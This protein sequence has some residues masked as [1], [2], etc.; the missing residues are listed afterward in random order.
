MTVSPKPAITAGAGYPLARRSPGVGHGV[1]DRVDPGMLGSPIDEPFPNRLIIAVDFGTTYSA[2]S[3][4]PVPQG[5]SSESV[6]PHS[7]QSIENY[8]SN[9]TYIANDQMV[10][11]VPT[12]VIYPLNRHFR[13]EETSNEGPWNV[14]DGVQDEA[15][16]PESVSDPDLDLDH[17]SRHD[18]DGDFDMMSDPS[19]DL[20]R[21]GYQVHELWSIP[22]T[23]SDSSTQPLSRFKLLLDSS[24]VT[25]T[26]REK[27]QATVNELKRQRIV[28]ESTNIIADF[29]THLLKHTQDEL[30]NQGFDDSYRKEIVLCVP[31]IWT[32]K[33]CRH[34]QT[35]L[36]IVMKRSCFQGVDVQNNSIENL[37]IVSEPEAAA[38]FVLT[39]RRDF[40]C[41]D[42]FV[43]LDAVDANTYKISN[44]EP[45]RLSQEVVAPGGGL[46]GSSFLNEKFGEYLKK[47]L[48]TETYLE[49]GTETINGIVEKII[50]DQ[51][52]YRIKRTFDIYTSA[53]SS[54]LF[55]VSGLR[56]NRSKRFKQGS[57]IVPLWVPMPHL[58][59]SQ[60]A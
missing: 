50:M 30:R 39:E 55:A 52:E 43:L 33:A 21:W 59:V 19:D 24:A 60:S 35:C 20:F 42:V 58:S 12:E 1:P 36:A 18:E 16:T 51:F 49:E 27:V 56:E 13:D 46:C 6:D 15:H 53:K 34:M 26:L 54:K 31:A 17:G 22:S 2:V 37:F 40:N 9:W 48:E 47:R 25:Q 41:G 10:V 5:C 3:Y 11:E 57:I 14:V 7:I 32:Q 8:P 29:L 38:A 28:K 4:V 45:L 44:K 23:H